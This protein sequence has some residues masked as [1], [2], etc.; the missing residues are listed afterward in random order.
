MN[1]K[2]P[3]PYKQLYNDSYDKICDYFR[4]KLL[5]QGNVLNVSDLEQLGLFHFD[6]GLQRDVYRDLFYKLIW[7]L[8]LHRLVTVNYEPYGN[9]YII[10][11]AVTDPDSVIGPPAQKSY[12]FHPQDAYDANQKALAVLVK[13]RARGMA[14]GEIVKIS[15]FLRLMPLPYLENKKVY[16]LYNNYITGFF[17]SKTKQGYFIRPTR[18]M[19]F[20]RTNK[21][22]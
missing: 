8:R 9:K 6:D 19:A 21:T 22:W 2:I 12:A 17:L 16:L 20:E 11:R 7:K 15:E 5:L 18:T 4:G 10:A 3:S 13:K 1:D 14:P